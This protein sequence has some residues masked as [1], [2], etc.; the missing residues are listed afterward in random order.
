MLGEGETVIPSLPEPDVWTGLGADEV[1]ARENPSALA[2]KTLSS[3]HQEAGYTSA[4]MTND[5]DPADLLQSVGLKK[6]CSLWNNVVK[7]W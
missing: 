2:A 3:P 7:V 4:V 5:P 1:E 6:R